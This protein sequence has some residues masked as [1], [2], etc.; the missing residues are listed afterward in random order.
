MQLAPN[1]PVEGHSSGQ[2][3]VECARCILQRHGPD[4]EWGGRS[5]RRVR[6]CVGQSLHEGHAP[7][8]EVVQ[9]RIEVLPTAVD[10]EEPYKQTGAQHT[11]R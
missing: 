3:Q 7:V 11:P 8:P 6:R 4:G 10:Y 5:G 1:M 2:P 9:Q